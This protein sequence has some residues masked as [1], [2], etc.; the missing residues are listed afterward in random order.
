MGSSTYQRLPDNV[1]YNV[2]A[3][4]DEDGYA[5]LTTNPFIISSSSSKKRN[6]SS[7]NCRIDIISPEHHFQ[8]TGSMKLIGHSTRKYKKLSWKISLDEKKFF[9]RKTLEMRGIA[10]EV[11]LMREKVASHLYN[12]VDVPTQEGAYARLFINGDV[13]GLYLLADHLDKEWIGAY[14]HGNEQSQIGIDYKLSSSTP[15]GPFCNLRYLGDDYK[16]YVK[17]STYS[18]N[19][20]DSGAIDT[21]SESSKWSSLVTFTKLFDDWVETYKNDKSDTAVKELKKFLNIESTLRLMAMDTLIMP[22]NNFFLFTSSTSLYYNPE[23]KNYQF[24][25]YEFEQVL[26]GSYGDASMNPNNYISDCITWVN[27][28]EDV[29]EHYFTNNLLSHPQ[30]KK[31][32]DVILAEILSTTYDDKCMNQYIQ[33]LGDLIR[34]DVQWN[35]DAVK[36]LD[37]PYDGKI[38]SMTMK[39]FED[40]ISYRHRTSDNRD[41]F[42]LGDFVA[43]RGK[44]CRAYTVDVDTSDNTNISD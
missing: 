13:Y 37:I 5:D 28:R 12:A 41:Y 9:G 2:V 26:L 16:L 29:N 11:S 15:N 24:I 8:S 25:P 30:I 20:Y 10:N 23:R 44:K 6:E 3:T 34:D 14:I 31:R 40:S 18:V 42:E 35:I 32:Y 7:M 22:I 27:Y 39:K 19:N 38:K 4:C 21:K 17:A 43:T 36:N 1:I 33:S